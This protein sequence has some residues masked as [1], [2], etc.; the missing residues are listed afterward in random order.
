MLNFNSVFLLI[1]ASLVNIKRLACFHLFVD[2]IL[3]YKKLEELES[4][5]KLT[6]IH[7]LI[8]LILLVFL[9]GNFHLVSFLL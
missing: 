6:F 3:M 7:C 4:W 2:F 5:L 8:S 9:S 1:G